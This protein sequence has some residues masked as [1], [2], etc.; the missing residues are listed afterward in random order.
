ML[1]IKGASAQLTGQRFGRLVVGK[2]LEGFAGKGSHWSCKCDC[3]STTV[4][5][6]GNL[7]KGTIKSCGCYQRDYQRQKHTTHN[8]YD[9]PRYRMWN[10]AAKRA[11]RKNLPFSLLLDDIPQIPE[12]CPILGIPLEK[13]YGV[14]GVTFNSPTLDR[15]IPSL[16]YV[17]GN[18]QIISQ[19]ANVIKNDASAEEIQK[20]ADYMKGITACTPAFS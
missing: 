13:S 1:P 20:V 17:P 18:I 4:A 19:R 10:S 11:R 2:R 15:I 16:G 9:T 8:Q 3:G 5:S 6:T 12:A 14:G 7:R